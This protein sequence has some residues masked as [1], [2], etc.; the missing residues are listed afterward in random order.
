MDEEI[1]NDKNMDIKNANDKL[2]S[3]KLQS[4]INH[5]GIIFVYTPPKVGSTTLVSS[6]RVSLSSKY[7]VIHIHDEIMLE[8]LTGIKNITI[9]DLIKYNASIG[10]KVYVIDIYRT[11]IER[12]MSEY[13]EKISC[14]HFNNTEDALNKYDMKLIINRFNK[15]FPH[16][17]NGDHY[18]DRYNVQP[19]LSFWHEKKCIVQSFNSIT[20]IKLRLVDSDEWGSILS[21][22]FGSKIVIINEYKTE[23]KHLGELFKKFKNEYKIPRNFLQD[24]KKDTYLHYYFTFEEVYEYIYMWNEKITDPFIPYTELEFK[25]YMEISLENCHY[26][27]I[28]F[29]HYVDNGCV[30]SLCKTKREIVFNKAAN[31]EKI[32]E[33]I[34]HTELVKEILKDKL[35][36]KISNFHNIVL[37][38]VSKQL[39]GIVVNI[40]KKPKLII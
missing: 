40:N 26:D 13:F 4:G 2:F 19:K 3:K 39:G 28:Q 29:D 18:L 8:K 12:K 16:L 38:D 37:N 6:L 22:I 21:D 9:D 11:P 33:K 7:S 36:E 32:S 34:N 30:C 15:L 1:N 23:N 20:Y 14:Y 31:G 10:K 35:K 24:I 5:E 25:L 17:G 27:I